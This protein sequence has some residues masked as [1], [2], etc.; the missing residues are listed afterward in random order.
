MLPKSNGDAGVHAY[1][2]S[3]EPW[4][5]SGTQGMVMLR[6]R[7]TGSV[8]FH[9]ETFASDEWREPAYAVAPLMTT[10]PNCFPCM[11]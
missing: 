5:P 1:I 6:R 9:T 4:Q 7:P 8:S 10:L 3:V 11:K 2:A